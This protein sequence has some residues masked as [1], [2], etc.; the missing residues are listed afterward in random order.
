[1]KGI[2]RVQMRATRSNMIAVLI[3]FDYGEAFLNNL[4][5]EDILELGK[6]VGAWI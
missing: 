4:P 5:D 3:A 1:M 6:K 2:S